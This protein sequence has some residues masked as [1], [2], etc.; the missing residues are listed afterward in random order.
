MR[1]YEKRR[2][3]R[4]TSGED[5]EEWRRRFKNW[6]YL[7]TDHQRNAGRYV[8]W[9]NRRNRAGMSHMKAKQYKEWLFKYA[10][11]HGKNRLRKADPRRAEGFTIDP[12]KAMLALKKYAGLFSKE[13][14]LWEE[15]MANIL[16]MADEY[17]ENTDGS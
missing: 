11:G 8:T 3:I 5:Y 15:T 2:Y 14:R 10:L 4:K 17:A 7:D 6:D 16:K 13:E 9:A 12:V 1:T